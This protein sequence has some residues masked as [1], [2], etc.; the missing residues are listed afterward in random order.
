MELAIL[1]RHAEST[2]SAQDLLNGDPDVAV[3]LTEKGREEARSLGEWLRGDRRVDLAVT[4]RFIRTQETASVAL[5]GRDVPTEVIPELDDV[6]LG[7]FEGREVRE[8]RAWQ[9]ANGVDT[10]IPGGGESRIDAMR[11]FIA[12]YRK[13]LARPEEAIL[14]VTHG[15]PVSAVLLALRGEEV[16]ITLE[17]VQV[18]PAEPH[19]VT[20]GELEFAVHWLDARMA[21]AP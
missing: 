3:P 11:R 17:K 16:P 15:L 12:G 14:V 7:E 6:R 8:F 21:V 20:A 1:T 4:S 5:A 19:P 9:R 10:R 13:V 18:R 2:Y